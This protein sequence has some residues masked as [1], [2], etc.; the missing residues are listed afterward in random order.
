MADADTCRLCTQIIDTHFGSL[1]AVSVCV[2][3]LIPTLI[4][5]LESRIRAVDPRSTITLATR[6]LHWF[7]AT[8][9]PCIHHRPHTTQHSLACPHGRGRRNARIQHNRVSPATQVWALR[10]VSGEPL[11][12]DGAFPLYRCPTRHHTTKRSFYLDNQGARI[13]QLVLDHGK[14]RPPDIMSRLSR[15]D[16]KSACWLGIP[17]FCRVMQTP[18]PSPRF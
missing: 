14:L 2:P 9:R 15:D 12:T 4:S 17:V 1:T 8:H 6:P 11:W 7:E 5:L 16:P 3:T 18:P 10:V 13:V